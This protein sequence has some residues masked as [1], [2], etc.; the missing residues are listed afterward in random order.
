MHET[1]RYFCWSAAG[2]LFCR[3]SKLC[4]NKKKLRRR[5]SEKNLKKVFVWRESLLLL[6]VLLLWVALLSLWY[7]SCQARAT[8]DFAANT[9]ALPPPSP[10]CAAQPASHTQ[11]PLNRQRQGSFCVSTIMSGSH[12]RERA[13]ERSRAFWN[14]LR[15]H[16]LSLALSHAHSHSCLYAKKCVS[17]RNAH[18]NFRG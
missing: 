13:S 14:L 6:V 11:T 16:S 9:P 7:N 17:E 3:Q 15:E 10:I 18:L 5:R 12:E 1:K 2:S 8:L 4:S